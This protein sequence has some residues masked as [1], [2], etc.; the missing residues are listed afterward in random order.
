MNKIR[1][2]N[3]V[4]FSPE[5]AVAIEGVGLHEVMERGI[6]ERQ[7]GLQS[8]QFMYFYQKNWVNEQD[9]NVKLEKPGLII[10]SPGT[11]HFYGELSY[12]WDCSW[13]LASGKLVDRFLQQSNIPTDKIL[14]PAT[15]DFFEKYVQ[16]FYYEISEPGNDSS[17]VARNLLENFCIEFSRSINPADNLTALHRKINSVISLVEGDYYRKWSLNELADYVNMSKS[18]FCS[19]FK[20]QIGTTPLDYII[21]LRMHEALILLK[22]NNVSISEVAD[23]LGYESLFY[24][25]RQFKKYF[26]VS[27]N[28]Y[29]KQN[30][31]T[32]IY[33]S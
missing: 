16:A 28:F 24:F 13:I 11:R 29:R 6:I 23:S 1:Y 20:N 7:F 26:N 17:I 14:Y 32:K 2:F 12:T 18:Y 27:P 3:P 30:S 25:S 5:T 31:S 19:T 15:I 33:P 10:W 4:Q 9:K 22:N 21:S 8:Y